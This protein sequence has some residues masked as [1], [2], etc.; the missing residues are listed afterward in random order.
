MRQAVSAVAE[1]GRRIFV[2]HIPHELRGKM[3][4]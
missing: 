2:G 4:P 1:I 3:K